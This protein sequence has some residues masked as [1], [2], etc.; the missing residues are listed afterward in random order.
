MD[1]AEESVLWFKNIFGDDYYLEMQRHE[2]HDPNADQEVYP[3]Q[4]IVNK[5]LVQ[6][7]RKHNIKLI[8]TNDVHFVNEDDAEAH[9]RLICLSTGKDIDDPT[10]LRYSKQEW[11]KT[12]AEMSALFSDYPEAIENTMEIA[13]KVEFYDIDSPALMPF[14]QID[15]SFGTEEEYRKKYSEE[16]LKKEFNEFDDNGVVIKDNYTRLGGYDKVIRIKFEADFL[17]HLTLERAKGPRRYNGEIPEN[18]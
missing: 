10:R 11:L 12:T 15:P 4:V 8:A 3:R 2:T 16:D 1:K 9:D 17:E 18:V 7:A 13:N 6:L 5:G 14:F